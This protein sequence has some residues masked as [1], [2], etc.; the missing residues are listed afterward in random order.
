MNTPQIVNFNVEVSEKD[1]TSEDLDVLTRQLLAELNDLEV[2]SAQL[3][4]ETAAP[5]GTK[6]VDPVTIGAIAVAVLPTFLPKIVE[7]IQAWALR[8]Q[9]RTVIFKGQIAGQSI[10]FEGHSEDLQKLIEALT[11]PKS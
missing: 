10:E 5:E 7:F 8:S 2:E 11:H 9:S 4:V 6:A 3:V 1:I